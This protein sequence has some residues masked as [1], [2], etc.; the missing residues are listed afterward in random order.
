[1]NNEFIWPQLF[2]SK[3]NNSSFKS[4]S[5]FILFYLIPIGCT[6]IFSLLMYPKL[7]FCFKKLTKNFYLLNGITA[8]VLI[9]LNVRV[10]ALMQTYIGFKFIEGNYNERNK[11]INKNKENL[12]CFKSEK[13]RL[14]LLKEYEMLENVK[15]KNIV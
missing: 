14:S 8:F 3:S 10:Y 11:L 15:S 12:N 9:S 5:K 6:S 7:I 13:L 4:Y 2:T 1:M